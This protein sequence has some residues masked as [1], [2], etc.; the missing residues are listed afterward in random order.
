MY[1]GPSH[2]RQSLPQLLA[3]VLIQGTQI[4]GKAFLEAGR[5]A[6]RNFR[7]TP[8]AAAG[9]AAAG[10]G[11]DAKGD[12]LTRTHRMTLEEARMI[13][14]IKAQ[15]GEALEEAREKLTKVSSIAVVKHIQ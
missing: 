4:V 6:G 3:R 12:Q 7:A 1:F 15:E 13:L 14:N 8:E 9:G 11:S 10:S 2:T 5:Q